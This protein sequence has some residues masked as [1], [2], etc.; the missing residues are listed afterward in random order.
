MRSHVSKPPPSRGTEHIIIIIIIIIIIWGAGDA[1]TINAGKS[2]RVGQQ[3]GTPVVPSLKDVWSTKRPLGSRSRHLWPPIGW[4]P[5]TFFHSFRQSERPSPRPTRI[6]SPAPVLPFARALPLLPP[7]F[8][9]RALAP[10]T[11]R[12]LGL[13][14]FPSTDHAGPTLHILEIAL[15][16]LDDLGWATHRFCALIGLASIITC[17]SGDWGFFC[18]EDASCS[19][20]DD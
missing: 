17:P 1:R 2:L 12:F 20:P 4:A 7:A 11:F 3:R 10:H 5:C 15:S 13:H 8:H 6:R 19:R 14:S 9:P 18:K 16:L